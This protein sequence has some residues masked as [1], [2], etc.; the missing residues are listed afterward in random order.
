MANLSKEGNIQ[1]KLGFAGLLITLVL[2]LVTL[3]HRH[4]ML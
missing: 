1:H 4:S 2:F 3:E